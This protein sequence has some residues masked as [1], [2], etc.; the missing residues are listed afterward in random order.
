MKSFALSK[1][2]AT[3]DDFWAEISDAV[4]RIEVLSEDSSFPDRELAAL[5]ASKVYYHLGELDDALAYALAAGTRFDLD[6]SSLYAS[7][8]IACAIDTYTA[9]TRAAALSNGPPVDE[10]LTAVVDRM[11]ERCFRTQEYKQAIGVALE[12]LRVDIFERAVNTSGAAVEMLAY[13]YEVVMTLTANRKV[14]E[15]FLA[16]I[17][18]LYGAQSTPDHYAMC[19]CYMVLN[20]PESLAAALVP[21]VAGGGADTLMGYQ[22]AFD[23]YENA[24]QQFLASV[25]DLLEKSAA[26]SSTSSDE[27]SSDPTLSVA[28]AAAVNA[29]LSGERTLPLYVEFLS[30]NA[31]VDKLI[32]AQTKDL[33]RNNSIC[34]SALVVS[35]AYMYAG[36]TDIVFLKDNREWLMRAINW[37]KF[38]AVA[39]LGVIHKGHTSEAKT[40]LGPYLPKEGVAGSEYEIGGGYYAYGLI[41]ANHGGPA[42]EFL[43]NGLAQSAR[44]AVQH[45]GCLGLGL[46]AMGSRRADC[47]EQMNN[48]LENA[49]AVTGEAAGIGMGL[50]MLGSGDEASVRTMVDYAR[51]TQHE[52]IIRGLALGIALTMFGQLENASALIDELAAD[53][54][55]LLRVAACHTISLAYAGTGDN[56][57]LRRL[58]HTAVSDV[59]DDVR[60]AACMALGFVLSRNPEQL[61]SVVSLLCESFNPHVRYGSCMAL[62]IACA[63][64]GSAEA[65]KLIEPMLTDSTAFVRQ[66]A[67]V[68]LALVMIQQ[69][70]AH[71]KATWS[72][73]Q[74]KKTI[75][76]KH[77]DVLSKF[78]AIIA[79][80]IIE[81]GGRNVTVSICRDQG[82]VDV[83]SVV[84]LLLFSQFWNWFPMCHF[85]SLAF[86]PTAVIG[87]NADIKMPKINFAAA[88]KASTYAPPP[89]TEVPKEKEKEK[90]AVAVLSITS[91]AKARE[92]KKRE[93]EGDSDEAVGAAPMEGIVKGDENAEAAEGKKKK[94]GEG[95]K[96]QE[97]GG[98]E[99]QEEKAEEEEEEPETHELPNPARV[100][101][102]MLSFVSLSSESRYQ[103]VRAGALTAGIL[104]MRDVK[105]GEDEDLIET[106]TPSSRPAPADTAGEPAPPEPFTFDP[107][108]EDEE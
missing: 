87:V 97:D 75:K 66:A 19:R 86:R 79:Q 33:I 50:V 83:P 105:P 82:H 64:T 57:V 78:G 48:I 41:N 67:S 40:I 68:S 62:G 90:V 58:L 56:G 54:D 93:A 5:V 26:S 38:S 63:G 94:Q 102:A 100:V 32:L 18:R 30:R 16:V 36:T 23:L 44:P 21:L 29:I 65:I 28:D 77:E 101:P 59:S 47:F 12:S 20:D 61:P 80:G 43:L 14:R 46:A 108:K 85:L 106:K 92:A 22:L 72:R 3:V 88:C 31:R 52:K 13:A 4:D 73:D 99:G 27:S 2:D 55:A 69:P 49:D 53:K 60:R 81:A 6:A 7:T 8:I 1:L 17:A 104:V 96:E 37:A 10:R 11:F 76:E 71:P 70:N 107:D 95:K 91:K 34:H 45:G 98:E 51:E 24:S 89:D 42:I 35:N 25:R 9:K 15:T 103:P 39:S 74:F 84:G